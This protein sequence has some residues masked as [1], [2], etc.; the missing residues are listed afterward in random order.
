M[1]PESTAVAM[2]PA[3]CNACCCRTVWLLGSAPCEVA[4]R[5]E[6][7]PCDALLVAPEPTAVAGP[8][9]CSARCG[10]CGSA[11][12]RGG[13]HTEAWVRGSLER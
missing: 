6:P 3:A 4:R 7:A 9:A 13:C 12:A 5:L 11:L 1:A 2:R 8:L 10:S